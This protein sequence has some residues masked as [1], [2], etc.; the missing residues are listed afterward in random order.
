M[1]LRMLESSYMAHRKAL[2]R[3]YG[4]SS[5]PKTS[6][7]RKSRPTTAAKPEENGEL[8][9]TG[10]TQRPKTSK[11]RQPGTAKPRTS[12]FQRQV[13]EEHESKVNK[14]YSR[15][16][17]VKPGLDNTG[18]SIVR[19]PP[20]HQAGKDVDHQTNVAAMKHHLATMKGTRVDRPHSA[21]PHNKPVVFDMSHVLAQS[22]TRTLAL[23]Q[24]RR[25]GTR[26]R[27]SRREP[28]KMA[29]SG[30]T[31]LTI[32]VPADA[33]E[34]FK[35]EMAVTVTAP[36]MESVTA[37]KV[38]S[39]E[40]DRATLRRYIIEEQV[41]RRVFKTDDLLQFFDEMK[42]KYSSHPDIDAVI[43]G[44][45]VD[46]VVPTEDDEE[47]AVETS[48]PL[49]VS[50]ASQWSTDPATTYP[51]LPV[52]DNGDGL[53]T[54]DEVKMSSRVRMERDIAMKQ[55]TPERGPIP[56][57]EESEDDVESVSDDFED[58]FEDD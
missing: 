58:D 54:L 27:S 14:M 56:D 57:H 8:D 51:F 35:E 42:G 19:R 5:R 38:P 41:S 32:E 1:G 34:E 6:K 17:A 48:S 7:T 29:M 52:V 10:T 55:K 40:F 16:K 47:V 36:A 12:K 37:V 26:P 4:A 45:S 24:P 53:R 49:K 43:K 33:Q 2:D 9:K 44:L 50:L 25:Q 20:T 13:Q 39:P 15:I 30:S 46:L 31:K 22:P 21:V 18:T 11:S 28:A 23:T 3:I